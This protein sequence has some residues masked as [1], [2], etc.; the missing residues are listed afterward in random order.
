MSSHEVPITPWPLPPTIRRAMVVGGTFDPPHRGHTLLPELHRDTVLADAGLVFVPAA[1]S[2]F[3]AGHEQTASADRVAMIRLAIESI[4]NAVVWKDEI[5]RSEVE[6]GAPSYTVDTIRRARHVAS[7][8]EL[9]LSIGADQALAFHK[10]REFR[11]IMRLAEIHVMPRG[12][13]VTP[14]QFELEMARSGVWTP[15]ETSE[16]A[17]R[18]DPGGSYPSLGGVSASRIREA[19]RER[20]AYAASEWMEL[21]VCRY[22][23][24]HGLYGCSRA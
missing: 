13:C 17:S 5:D 1:V 15:E 12:A 7:G 14:K 19:I 22:I 20:G 2:P 16:W 18:F 6:P 23:E 3:K 10:W 24:Q 8:V 21:P 11:E 9:H 4:P